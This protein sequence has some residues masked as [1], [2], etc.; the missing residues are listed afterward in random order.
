[1]I[2][3]VSAFWGLQFNGAKSNQGMHEVWQAKGC[4]SRELRKH[5]KREPPRS[6]QDLY[7]AL[8]ETVGKH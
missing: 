6:L 2:E 3:A 5:P 8:C 1:M 4:K 7:A